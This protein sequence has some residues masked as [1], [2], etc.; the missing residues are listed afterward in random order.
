MTLEP[1]YCRLG[2]NPERGWDSTLNH[3]PRHKPRTFIFHR[4]RAMRT[5]LVGCGSRISPSR[6][7]MLLEARE[8]TQLLMHGRSGLISTDFSGS[9]QGELGRSFVTR[10]SA[11]EIQRGCK[12]ME[13]K[14]LS[15][16]FGIRWKACQVC[17]LI[18]AAPVLIMSLKLQKWF[19]LCSK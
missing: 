1:L 19:S 7:S 3:T 15:R 13:T 9:A 12:W 6:W 14:S 4:R 8:V 10:S 16:H 11:D 18:F 2:L 5:G 17:R